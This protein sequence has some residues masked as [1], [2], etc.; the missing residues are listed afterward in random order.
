MALE[1]VHFSRTQPNDSTKRHTQSEE[2][3][4]VLNAVFLLLAGIGRKSEIGP[5]QMSSLYCLHMARHK[6]HEP[7]F[8]HWRTTKIVPIYLS[9]DRF[10]GCF[11]RLFNLSILESL[12]LVML[13]L[14]VS[15]QRKLVMWF[16]QLNSRHTFSGCWKS[17]ARNFINVKNVCNCDRSQVICI[18]ICSE[19]KR[20]KICG[21]NYFFQFPLK[22]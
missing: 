9:N 15:D 22:R 18:S 17:Y 4:F 8:I 6:P 13:L 19:Q 10:F 7:I 1:T 20:Y 16:F 21:S 11:V 14:E 2:N 12:S 3:D 5:I